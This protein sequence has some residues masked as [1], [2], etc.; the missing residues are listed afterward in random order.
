MES[1][2]NLKIV[3]KCINGVRKRAIAGCCGC[4]ASNGKG[5]E[6]YF[7]MLSYMIARE[8]IMKDINFSVDAFLSDCGFTG[9][10]YPKS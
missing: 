3:A 4:K 7:N 9:K 1:R 6:V 5:V 2:I 10:K 8:L